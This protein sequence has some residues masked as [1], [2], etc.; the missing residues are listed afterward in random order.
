MQ[1]IIGFVLLLCSIFALYIWT[2]EPD[3]VVVASSGVAVREDAY[4]NNF[5]EKGYVV[6]EYYGDKLSGEFYNAASKPLGF[7]NDVATAFDSFRN[8]VVN[9][10]SSAGTLSETLTG[11]FNFDDPNS[12]W[13]D[14]WKSFDSNKD[15]PDGYRGGR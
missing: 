15:N 5:D 8:G 2:F 3:N 6:P 7:L 10:I 14:I 13:A 1:K 11:I 4:G 12:W 9:L